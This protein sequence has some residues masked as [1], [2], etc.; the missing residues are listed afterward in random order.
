METIKLRKKLIKQFEV[1]LKDEAKLHALEG[2]L[3]ALNSG[4]GLSNV[5]NAHYDLIHETRKEYLN[6]D[7]EGK[8]WEDVKQSLIVKYGL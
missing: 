4:Q 2:L 6:K 5:P 3:D 8:S 7:C 1:I